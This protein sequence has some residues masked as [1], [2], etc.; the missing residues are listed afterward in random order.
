MPGTE[1]APASCSDDNQWK[2]TTIA[3]ISAEAPR[4]RRPG[5]LP[6]GRCHAGGAGVYT[7]SQFGQGHSQDTRVG[8]RVEG[9][10]AFCEGGSGPEGERLG[11]GTGYPIDD[12]VETRWGDR[13]SGKAVMYTE[14]ND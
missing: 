4:C 9:C 8:T 10:R 14:W 6:V 12:W 11:S 7:V 5:L 13:R 2:A 3:L 1:A